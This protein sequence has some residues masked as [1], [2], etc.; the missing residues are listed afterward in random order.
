MQNYYSEEWKGYL[1]GSLQSLL[2]MNPVLYKTITPS[3][4][5]EKS[6]VYLISE[7]QGQSEIALYVGRSKNLRERLYRQHLM[8]NTTS[9]RLKKYMI[10]DVNHSCHGDVKA[11]KKYIQDHCQVRWFLESD[12]RKRGALEG[13]FTAKFFPD[14]GIA[15]EH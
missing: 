10:N 2:L 14:Y 12:T 3:Q 8:G 6:G 5:P 13:F 11:A 4:L 1:E 15:E 9:A 7:I